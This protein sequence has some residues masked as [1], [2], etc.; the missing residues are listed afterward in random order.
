MV[1]PARKRETSEQRK[2]RFVRDKAKHYDKMRARWA[3]R[4]AL[5]TGRIRKGR[6]YLAGPDCD[7]QIQAH[8]DDYSKPLQ[9]KW[10]C[11][12]HHVA[13]DKRMRSVSA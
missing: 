9:I 5:K 2:A 3:A 11:R 4:Y 13:A 6:C 7:G 8:H 1:R 10:L 12:S